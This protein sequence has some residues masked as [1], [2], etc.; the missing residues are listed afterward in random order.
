MQGYILKIKE[1]KEFN[2][3]LNELNKKFT[4]SKGSGVT[5]I[6]NEKKDIENRGIFLKGTTKKILVKKED[7]LTFL[8]L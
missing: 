5:L 3:E 2:N 6:N 1:L 7:Y 4:K 8:V